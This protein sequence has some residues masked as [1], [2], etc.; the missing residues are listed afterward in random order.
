MTQPRVVIDTNCLLQIL[1]AKSKYHFLFDSFLQFGYVLCI[2]NEVLLE[3]EE[4]LRS[5]ASPLAADL[6][7]KVVARSR[8]VIRKDPYFKWGIITKDLDDNK[9]VDCAF[10]CRADYIITN[11]NHFQEVVDSPFPSFTVMDLDAFA[12]LMKQ[13]QTPQKN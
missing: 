11:D 6:F 12:G 3:Y 4:I 13:Q 8:N 7:L 1:G 5:K 9:F 2:S 10:A